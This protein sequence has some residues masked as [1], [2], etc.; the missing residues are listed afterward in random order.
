MKFYYLIFLVF[1]GLNQSLLAQHTKIIAHRGI[2]NKTDLPENSIASLKAAAEQKV[3]G[4]EFDIHL[5]KDNKLVVN[6]DNDFYG[7]D[8]PSSTYKELLAK[9]LP[10]GENI[11]TAKEYLEEGKKHKDLKLIVEIKTN[12]KGKERTQEAAKEAYKLI[13]KLGIKEQ[14]VFIAFSYDACLTL[15]NLDN[16]LEIQYL[17]GDKSPEELKKD[18]LTGMD[19]HF[20]VFKKNPEW[21]KEAKNI[22]I[23][24]N[25]WT[26]NKEE[27]IRRLVKEGIDF[28]TTD[29]PE[30]AQKIVQEES[31]NT[32]KLN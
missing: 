6:H 30:L 3:W 20:S 15:K 27:E 19:Y 18:G 17:D 25:A 21:I 4:S 11:P 31:V 8:I 24:S 7:I 13:K 26:V 10:N 28:I 5:T 29:E 12:P 1:F 2:H 16:S 23:A 9:K 22:D 14:V 32:E